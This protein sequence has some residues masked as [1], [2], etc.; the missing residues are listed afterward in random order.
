MASKLELR[1]FDTGSV[2]NTITI[3]TGKTYIFKEQRLGI[4]QVS[5]GTIQSPSSPTVLAGSFKNAFEQDDNLSGEYTVNYY[6]TSQDAA[7]NDLPSGTLHGIVT[8]EHFDNTHFDTFDNQSL[9][10]V[11]S[12]ITTTTQE[13]ESTLSAATSEA[14]SNPC[15]NYKLTVTTNVS[16]G[17]IVV[18]SPIGTQIASQDPT[19]GNPYAVDLTRPANA[20]TGIIKLFKVS[21]DSEPEKTI[22]FNAPPVLALTKVDKQGSPFGAVATIKSTSGLTKTY[23]FDGTNYSGSNQ[24]GGLLAGSYTAYVKDDLGCTKSLAFTITEAEVNGNTVPKKIEIPAHNAMYF[25]DRS[26]DNF[27]GQI[28]EEI[29][30]NAPAK[31]FQDWLTTD[32][33]PIQFRSSYPVHTVK[34]YECGSEKEV[35][36]IQKSNNINR[37]N[38]YEGNFTE[39]EGRLAIYFTSG[40]IYED[41]GITPKPEGHILNGRLPSWYKAGVFVKID[42]VGVT[43]IER[44][45]FEDD[46]TYAITQLDAQGTV[47]GV[48]IWTKHVEHP[49]EIFE[50]QVNMSSIDTIGE[51]F[52]VEIDYGDDSFVSEL[53]RVN[54]SLPKHHKISWRN[55]RQ[56]DT[57]NYST[58][59]KPFRRQK[60]VKPFTYIGQNESERHQS[61]ETIELISSTSKAVYELDLGFMSMEMCHGLIDGTNHASEIEIDGAVFITNNPSIPENF[62]NWYNAKMELALIGQNIESIDVDLTQINVSFLKVNVD[63][64]GVGFLKL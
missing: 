24:L 7:G 1:F 64:G 20:T 22:L 21:G 25:V 42:G 3:A 44:L 59:I 46:A 29:T 31:V 52:V 18:E 60:Y 63:S 57:I 5:I 28:S 2:N 10:F 51:A 16:G 36:V 61:D 12:E 11:S 9:L 56:N 54:A 4:R 40:N 32:I 26:Q 50:F 8:I 49:F 55:I 35:S 30:F 17:K 37:L 15:G 53:Q 34:I 58:G 39:K 13:T 48:P 19:D 33:V 41:D 47:T 43:Q 45:L 38:I 23:S 62:G 6:A 27:L 14:S